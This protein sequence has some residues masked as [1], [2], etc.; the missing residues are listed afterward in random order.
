MY[1][2]FVLVLPKP[3]YDLDLEDPLPRPWDAK[4]CK[5]SLEVSD[6]E[7]LERPRDSSQNGTKIVAV[8]FE[9]A[10]EVR[11][12]VVVVAMVAADVANKCVIFLA[13]NSAQ[14]KQDKEEEEEEAEEEEEELQRS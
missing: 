7:D 8:V 9:V 1:S 6:Q 10:V 11:L 2:C 13:G 14:Y 3:F 5:C 4:I 12:V